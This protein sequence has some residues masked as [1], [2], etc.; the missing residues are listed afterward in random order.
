MKKTLLFYFT[1]ILSI[2]FALADIGSTIQNV[3]FK[4]LGIG[5][6]S[7]LGIADGS[8]VVAFTR[9]LIWILIFAILFALTTS[10]GGYSGPLSF[11]KKNHAAVISFIIATIT[12]IFL[13]AQVLLAIGAGWGTLVGLILIG[14]PIL[15]IAL[16]FWKLPNDPCPYLMLKF[17]LSLLI[18]WILS[19]MKFH[20]GK[21]ITT[22]SPVISTVQDFID[23]AMI[24]IIL[25]AIYYF[26]RWLMC[27]FGHLSGG[28]GEF[29]NPFKFAK[30]HGD[31]LDKNTKAPLKSRITLE[32]NGKVI[33]TKNCNGKYEF[34]FLK[35]EE[36]KVISRPHKAEYDLLTNTITL[37][38]K[39]NKESSFL[40]KKGS[41]GEKGKLHGIIIDKE[42]RVPIKSKISLIKDGTFIRYHYY[43]GNYKIENLDPGNY[44]L[45][46][47]PVD[48]K[49]NKIT[50]EVILSG[51]ESKEADFLHEVG[52]DGK[53][54]FYGT[55]K[56]D[57]NSKIKGKIYLMK[58]RTLIKESPFI[59]DYE[60]K[61]IEPGT[62]E[63]VSKP[64]NK[65]YKEIR[66][67]ESLASKE[68]KEVN[69][70]H[71][72]TSPGPGPE[73]TDWGAYLFKTINYIQLNVIMPLEDDS[74]D[75]T[76]HIKN[77][78]R[79]WGVAKRMMGK[80]IELAER[81][82]A[83]IEANRDLTPE[84]KKMMVDFLEKLNR[85]K[86]AMKKKKPWLFNLTDRKE[87]AR[88]MREHFTLALG[89]YQEQTGKIVQEITKLPLKP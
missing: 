19:A 4:I 60:F 33:N 72:N 78:A 63:L 18:F 20:T 64:T 53:G 49:Y 84:V 73:K 41:S 61:D 82:F 86:G 87:T 77:A 34:G 44:K 6:L 25:I 67:T 47:E 13:P 43:T 30:V 42:T 9:I 31:I 57:K 12:A 17:F 56:N 22:A 74:G 7:F 88:L 28:D 71:P 81:Y 51:G 79:S 55:I 66:K 38:H 45:I 16:L 39:D 8:L 21:M 27:L 83:F 75:A 50:T 40:H 35:P 26:I 14:S 23:Y 32:R 76:T 59:G 52:E 69:F 36:Y 80:A 29:V 62:Y 24:I 65:R 37:A 15:A 85:L 58:G 10:L 3:W 2:P 5:S 70:V 54:K 11:L 68:A 1:F 48:P 89:K 46:S